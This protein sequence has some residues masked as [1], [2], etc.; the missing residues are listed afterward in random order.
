MVSAFSGPLAVCSLAICLNLTACKQSADQESPASED[1]YIV[2]LGTLQDGGA[3]HAGCQKS[4]CSNLY[5]NPDPTKKVVCLGLVDPAS[6]K[7]WLFE[8]TPD[9]PNQLNQM[10]TL[11]DS[12]LPKGIFL[13]HAHIGHYAGLIHLGK[14]VMNADKIPVYTMPRMTEYLQNHGPWSQLVKLENI[15][16]KQL[17]DEGEITLAPK[18]KVIP[19][20]VPHRDE[21]SETVGFRIIGP[22]K[23][24][25]F[26]PDINKWHIWDEDVKEVVEQNDYALLDATFYDSEE[27]NNRNMDEIPHP[28]VVETMKTFEAAS[29]KTKNKIHFIHLNHTN[30]LLDTNS[31]AYRNSIEM[32]FR[33]AGFLQRFDL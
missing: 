14:E 20:L 30:P 1:P 31:A 19:F 22:N 6:N 4:C 15:E 33:I 17:Q 2:V 23:S 3:P 25:I 11:V 5:A 24:L 10:Y 27:L 12:G 8:A 32:N 29:A 21:F 26:I 7:Y 9:F 28:F 16:L 13:S 18:L